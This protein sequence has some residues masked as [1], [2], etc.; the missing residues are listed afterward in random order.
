[1]EIRTES[2][3]FGADKGSGPRTEETSV[4]MSGPISQA[5]A[6]LTGIEVGF[7][8]DDGDH[9]LGNLDVRLESE[10]DPPDEVRVTVSYGLRDWSG[11][12]DDD[13]EGRISFAVIAE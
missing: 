6:I 1:M 13:Y 4:Q 11:D 3:Q 10:I 9:E 12:W 7:S 2:V 8:K 5:V